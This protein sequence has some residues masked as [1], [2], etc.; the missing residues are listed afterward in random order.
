MSLQGTCGSVDVGRVRSAG[1]DRQDVLLA[2]DEQFV[3]VDLELGPGVLGVQDLV[4]FLDVHGLALA[5]LE[6]LPGAGGDDRAFLGLLL[7]TIRQDDAALCYLLPGGR[8][9]D[10]AVAERTELRRDRS[11]FGQRAFLL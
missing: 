6:D 9:D 2:D 10:D 8:L 11:G 1:D 7:Y 3:V 4:P 5:V